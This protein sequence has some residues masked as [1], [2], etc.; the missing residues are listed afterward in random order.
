MGAGFQPCGIL[1]D[2]IVLPSALSPGCCDRSRA[3]LF[4]W[5]S[6]SSRALSSNRAANRTT[7]SGIVRVETGRAST[8]SRCLGVAAIS[9]IRSRASD[10][11][12][13]ANILFLAQITNGRAHLAS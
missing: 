11:E 13:G 10:A 3:L 12:H 4:L 9:D 6:V 2:L 7:Q 8:P 1:S 5:I